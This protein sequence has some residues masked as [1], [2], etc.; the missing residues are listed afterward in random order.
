LQHRM[1]WRGR[2]GSSLPAW[3]QQIRL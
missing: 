2:H 3:L 1:V